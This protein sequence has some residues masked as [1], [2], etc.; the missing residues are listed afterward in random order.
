MAEELSLKSNVDG[1]YQYFGISILFLCN[2]DYTVSPLLFLKYLSCYHSRGIYLFNIARIIATV[3][4][5]Q[6][7]WLD[8]MLSSFKGI[9]P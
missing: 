3:H 4:P 7:Q 6:L 9:I 1:Y 8:Y 5:S 2:I